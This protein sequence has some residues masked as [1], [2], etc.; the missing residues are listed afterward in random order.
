VPKKKG[1]LVNMKGKVL[2]LIIGI[3]IGAIITTAGF[4]IYNKTVAKNSNQPD[5]MQM[6][7]KGQMGDPSNGDGKTMGDPPSGDNNGE[8]P[9]KPDG[10][11][12]EEPPTKPDEANSNTSSNN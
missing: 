2:T 12:G 7:G 11:N 9:E 3:L 5:M 4:L 6:D 1:M 10:D 8:A